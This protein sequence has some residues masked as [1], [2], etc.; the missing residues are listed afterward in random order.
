VFFVFLV[1][2]WWKFIGEGNGPMKIVGVIPSRYASTRFPGKPLALILGKPLILHTIDQAKQARLLDRVVVATDD[3][4]IAKVVRDAG[5]EVR[6][7]SPD[8]PTG[9]DRVAQ[10][11]GHEDWDIVVN[12]QGDEPKVDP[13]VID[14]A[15]QALIDMPDCGV[16]TA[17]VALRNREDYE[18]SSNVKVVCAPDG[19]ALYFSRS[20]IPSPARL[21][22]AEKS[23]PG[24]VW[25]MKH[26]GLY[27]FRKDVLMKFVKWPQTPLEK[28]EC[29]EQLRLMEHGIGI[30]VVEVDHDSI[31]VDTP[32]ELEQLNRSLSGVK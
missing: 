10:A 24:F 20:P 26:L 12:I 23:A 11:I 15:V 22:E 6:M 2:L 21:S 14:R 18:A 19:R 16:S 13:G 1:S 4:R 31:G 5:H 7:T 3:D 27:A 30:R 9:S 28:R 29:L 17:M 25:G 8:C 32:E